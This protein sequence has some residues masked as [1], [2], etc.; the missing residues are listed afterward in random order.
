MVEVYLLE[1]LMFI[2]TG[3]KIEVHQ[4]RLSVYIFRILLLG[5]IELC[6]NTYPST[7]LSSS[8]LHVCHLVTII[9]LWMSPAYTTQRKTTSVQKIE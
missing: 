4:I 5:V 6:W 3:G 1:K 9:G 7:E 2:F 8:M